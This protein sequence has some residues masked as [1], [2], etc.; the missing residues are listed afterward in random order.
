[1]DG[2]N[3]VYFADDNGKTIVGSG[4]TCSRC[5]WYHEMEFFGRTVMICE[6]RMGLNTVVEPNDYC[7]K[8]RRKEVLNDEEM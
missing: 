2:N 6:N 8:G 7:S 5:V 4:V 3:F 1:M